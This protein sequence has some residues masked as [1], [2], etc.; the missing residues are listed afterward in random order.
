MTNKIAGRAR[1]VLIAVILALS[2]FVI[3]P[4]F[5]RSK[6]KAP[7]KPP[8]KSRCA[9]GPGNFHKIITNLPRVSRSPSLAKT[10]YCVKVESKHG[11]KPGYIDE[12]FRPAAVAA[13]APQTNL[14]SVAGPYRTLREID[15]RETP[16]ANSRVVT[17]LPADIKVNVLRPKAIG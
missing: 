11:G 9:R 3:G 15:L 14:T 2:G 13:A 4:R 10:G 1:T 5:A 12:Q 7:M 8:Q 16:S 17:R 6:S